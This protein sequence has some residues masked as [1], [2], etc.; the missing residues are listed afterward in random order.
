MINGIHYI[1]NPTQESVL[2]YLPGD[3]SQKIAPYMSALWSAI[4]TADEMPERVIHGCN[5]EFDKS[6][7]AFITAES[8]TF[9]RGSNIGANSRKIVIIDEAQNYTVSDLRK[10]LTRVCDGSTVIVIGQDVQCD[11]KDERLSGFT[12]CWKHFEHADS[13][14]AFFCKLTTCHR[15]WVADW[16]DRPW[17]EK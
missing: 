15:S 5:T 13:D 4:E 8:S 12:P 1:I 2:G 7:D 14:K 16:S 10:T 11:L 3:N 6:G 9:L 17:T